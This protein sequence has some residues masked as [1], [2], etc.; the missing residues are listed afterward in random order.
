MDMAVVE[1]EVVVAVLGMLEVAPMEVVMEKEVAV[2]VVT[3]LEESTEAAMAAVVGAEVAVEQVMVRE[4]L[5][6]VDMVVVGV[7][8]VVQEEDM[9]V[10]MA[11]AVLGAE[12]AMVPVVNMGADME[13]GVGAVKV[14]VMV[15]TPHENTLLLS[16]SPKRRNLL[17]GGRN[18]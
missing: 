13:K 14:V 1:V 9:Q 11:V 10:G 16:H 2:V 18:V 15:A 5:E 7:L 17:S 6:G 4:E 8:A 12:L 3:V